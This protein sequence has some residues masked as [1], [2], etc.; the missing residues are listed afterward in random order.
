MHKSIP[1]SSVKRLFEKMPR[2]ELE[3]GE[4]PSRFTKTLSATF[5]QWR[6]IFESK[7][8]QTCHWPRP[9]ATLEIE[10]RENVSPSLHVKSLHRRCHYGRVRLQRSSNHAISFVSA[11]RHQ[12]SSSRS[13]HRRRIP[14][15]KRAE[16]IFITAA[17]QPQVFLPLIARFNF[18]LRLRIT[19]GFSRKSGTNKKSSDTWE[20]TY[21]ENS[22]DVD[23]RKLFLR[24]HVEENRV[25][26]R[27]VPHTRA[28]ARI[29]TIYI[30]NSASRKVSGKHGSQC[31]RR[32]PLDGEK[33]R[34]PRMHFH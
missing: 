23:A 4:F 30:L 7:Y 19:T 5:N 34:L 22:V 3:H 28:R 10:S 8:F 12:E 32:A 24:K 9:W 25:F 2:K 6:R 13:P 21:E 17:R 11:I 16:P 33:L 14:F 29:Y 26:F 27:L 31:Q 15:V 20:A 1:E 18:S